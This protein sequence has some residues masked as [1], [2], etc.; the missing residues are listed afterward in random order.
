MKFQKVPQVKPAVEVWLS[1]EW[2]VV[3]VSLRALVGCLGLM[4]LERLTAERHG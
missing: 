4:V 3:L 1:E 2:T